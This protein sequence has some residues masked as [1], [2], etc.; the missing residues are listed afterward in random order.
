MAPIRHRRSEFAELEMSRGFA[1]G[2][3]IGIISEISHA[4][5]PASPKRPSGSLAALGTP[6]HLA[7]GKGP[8]RRGKLTRS[9]RCRHA[10]PAARGPALSHPEFVDG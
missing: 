5:L 6:S 7:D 4:L 3:H 9:A 8:N 10:A 2:L 1:N